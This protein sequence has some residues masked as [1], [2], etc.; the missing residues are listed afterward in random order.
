MKERLESFVKNNKGQAIA[1]VLILS[2]AL[3]FI[4]PK[5]YV[6]LDQGGRKI[7]WG[8]FLLSFGVI[9]FMLSPKKKEKVVPKAQVKVTPSSLSYQQLL[10]K[11]G[12]CLWE[13]KKQMIWA[14]GCLI[15]GWLAVWVGRWSGHPHYSHYIFA[16]PVFTL[17]FLAATRSWE[18]AH[19]LDMDVAKYTIEGVVQ[20]KKQ[21]NL[22]S[23]RFRAFAGS[24][25][26]S[27]MWKFAFIR[28]SPLLMIVFSFL[29]AG[30]FPLLVHQFGISRMMVNGIFGFTI[31]GLFLFFARVTC[32]PYHWML[33]K[34]KAV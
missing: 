6:F 1:V 14:Y 24:Y 7:F 31:A 26:G 21:P 23:D 16:I 17:T 29:N 32:R 5:V 18:K 28:V 4:V 11:A 10:D 33:D 12:D 3:I 2:F 9:M 30:I 20:E 19:N 15:V 25:D 8:T 13:L 22:K 27:G 34:M